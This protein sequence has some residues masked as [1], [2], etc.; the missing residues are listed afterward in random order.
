MT[1]NIQTSP[2]LVSTLTIVEPHFVG[3]AL[4]QSLLVI[5]T[6]E[7][8]SSTRVLEGM[9]AFLEKRAPKLVGA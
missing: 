7:I 4:L 5:L 2:S 3:T 9:S 8:D 6:K 1:V